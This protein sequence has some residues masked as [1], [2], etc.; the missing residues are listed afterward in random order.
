MLNSSFPG[1]NV[2]KHFTA[3]LNKSN[4]SSSEPYTQTVTVTGITSDM[5][6]I[7]D[8][9]LSA[10]LAV[11]KEEETNWAYVSKIETGTGEI[12]ATCNSSKPLVDLNI[13]LME[14]P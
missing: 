9:V 6:P 7:I 4:W 3:T 1:G 12:T 5:Q 11:A 10:T 2:S 13:R 14:V 8:I